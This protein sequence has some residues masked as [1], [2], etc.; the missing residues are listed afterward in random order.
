[1]GIIEDQSKW[2]FKKT[3]FL[4]LPIAAIVLLIQKWREERRKKAEESEE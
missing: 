2:F 3:L 4:W 1:M